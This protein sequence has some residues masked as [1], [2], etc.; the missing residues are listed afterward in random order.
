M[1]E[2]IVRSKREDL[3]ASSELPGRRTRL[4]ARRSGVDISPAAAGDVWRL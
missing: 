4:T 2:L 3:V 1:L